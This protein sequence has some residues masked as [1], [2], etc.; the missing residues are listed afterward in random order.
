MKH[1]EETFKVS[2][3]R[4]CQTIDQP[5]STQR[6]PARESAE[7]KRLTK[8][9]VELSRENPRYGYRRV[10]ALLREEGW[11]LNRKRVH[12]LW[13]REGLKIPVKQRKRRA[14]GWKG[15]QRIRQRARHPNHVWTYDFL[16][17][18]TVDGRRLK[19]LAIV[20][21][22]T[23]EC[24]AIHV[25]R[26]ITAEAVVSELSR[27]MAV[28]GAAVY[29]RSDNGPEFIA[30]RVRD[31]LAA[32]KTQTI[33]I[34]PG[35]PWENPYSES[36]NSRLR[37]ELLNRE[38]FTSLLE[39]RVL[40]EAYRKEYNDRRPHSSL[41]YRTPAAFAASCAFSGSA[42]LRR[43]RHMATNRS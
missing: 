8:R 22:F 27:L 17:D 26:S 3:R 9:L 16:M 24:L 33:Y 4:A 35:S 34:E 7:E 1:L 11:H 28:R 2:Q 6:Y 25:A 43:T 14:L 15:G 37:D 18:Q 39:A 13:R 30:K 20:D 38:V 42:T 41:G 5:R 29:V 10:T 12:R 40:L 32:R 31:W 19:I 36:F 23:R 21:E